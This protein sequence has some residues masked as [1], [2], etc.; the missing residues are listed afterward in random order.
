MELFS[1]IVFLPAAG[2]KEQ[3]K[4]SPQQCSW[5]RSNCKTVWDCS[6]GKPA[7][8]LEIHRYHKSGGD[9]RD[10]RFQKDPKIAKHECSMDVNHPDDSDVTIAIH[11]VKHI[12]YIHAELLQGF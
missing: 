9:Y 12:V 11:Q 7:V 1:L 10:P 3:Y 2:S 4:I 6:S 8:I 5:E